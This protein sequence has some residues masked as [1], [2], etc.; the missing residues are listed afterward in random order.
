MEAR[1]VSELI[2][3]PP[4]SV[5]KF[6]VVDLFVCFVFSLQ[7]LDADVRWD[8]DKSIISVDVWVSAEQTWLKTTIRVKLLKMGKLFQ[9]E[10]DQFI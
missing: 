4:A 7:W 8:T 9:C 6:T 1:K 10:N 5:L 2:I 3:C